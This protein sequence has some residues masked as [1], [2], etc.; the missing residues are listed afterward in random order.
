MTHIETHIDISAPP[1]R[2][3]AVLTDFA[4]FPEW[5]PFMRSI[6]GSPTEGARLN[7]RM[8][9]PGGRGM[10]FKPTVTV[11][12]PARE[13]R[14]LGR[15]G[16]PRI[17]DGEHQLLIEPQ[18]GGTTRFTQA[19]TFRGILVPFLKGSLDKTRVGFE[20][21]NAALKQRVEGAG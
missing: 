12:R 15:L 14:W 6:V 3:W 16:L 21:M 1:E 20:Q 8:E 19:E 7:V 18:A 5:N 17:F 4:A 9:P 10:T 2:V 13:L 11:A